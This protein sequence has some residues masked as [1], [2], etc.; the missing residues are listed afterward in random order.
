ML[1]SDTEYQTYYEINN[2]FGS[3][4]YV[5]LTI[6]SK[7]VFSNEGLIQLKA[8]RRISRLRGS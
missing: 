1:D 3:T 2:E 7:K 5:I 8:L 6:K 4:E